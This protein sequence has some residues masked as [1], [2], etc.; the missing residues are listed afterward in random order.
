MDNQLKPEKKLSKKE[1]LELILKYHNKKI[2]ES[3]EILVND[4]IKA[5]FQ[6]VVNTSGTVLLLDDFHAKSINPES[7]KSFQL[8]IGE[9]LNLLTKF[10]VKD[11]NRNRDSLL[12]AGKSEGIYGL[13]QLTFVENLDVK[14]P[15]PL[16]RETLFEKGIREK[17]ETGESPRYNLPE[18]EFDELLRKDIEKEKRSNEK[19]EQSSGI[20]VPEKRKTKKEVEQD[21]LN[22]II[23]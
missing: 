16:K 1:Q 22:K 14:F 23:K 10:D 9:R 12:R 7:E 8:G 5:C 19:V 17:E 11:I 15:V 21:E 3:N 20:K 18:N 4:V 13:P 6:Y 2:K